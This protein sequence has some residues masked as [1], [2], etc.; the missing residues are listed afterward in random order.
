MLLYHGGYRAIE[1]PR[2]IT[3]GF[4][5][6]FG[7]GFYCTELKEQAIRWSRRYTTP[8]V[9][10]FDYQDNEALKQLH[11][12]TMS[13]EWLDFIVSCRNYVAH[14]NALNCLTYIGSEAIQL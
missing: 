2:I 3:G 1:T 10:L 8:I 5:K 13:E 9:T 7:D 11:F 4:A 6:D 14:E 12:P